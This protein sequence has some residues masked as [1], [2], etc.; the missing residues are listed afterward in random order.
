MSKLLRLKSRSRSDFIERGNRPLSQNVGILVVQCRQAH[1]LIESWLIESW[2]CLFPADDHLLK[3]RRNHAALLGLAQRVRRDEH[4][5]ADFVLKQI[6]C[7][8]RNRDAAIFPDDENILGSA[9]GTEN[10]S[11]TELEIIPPERAP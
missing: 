7:A 4:R 8:K 9:M 10:V 1:D 2:F 6:V 3:C 5:R 11:V